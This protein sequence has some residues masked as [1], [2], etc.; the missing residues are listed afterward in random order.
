MSLNT[1][2]KLMLPKPENTMKT[3]LCYFVRPSQQDMED[4]RE[5]LQAEPTL[6]YAL[7]SCIAQCQVGRLT[8]DVLAAHVHELQFDGDEAGGKCKCTR[9]L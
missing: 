2:M 8:L 9:R 6:H 3:L 5:P 1:L 7:L 4:N